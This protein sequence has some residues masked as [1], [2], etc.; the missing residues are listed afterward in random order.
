MCY[1][2]Q[3]SGVYSQLFVVQVVVCWLAMELRM[4]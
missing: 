4:G 1:K 2:E 3:T